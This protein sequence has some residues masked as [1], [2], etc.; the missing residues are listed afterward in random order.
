MVQALDVCGVFK[1]YGRLSVL[2]GVDLALE[3]GTFTSVLGPSGS[4]K[5]TLLRVIAGFERIDVGSVSLNGE[6]VDDGA[7]FVTPDRRR[8]GYVP[9]E[10]SLFPHLT[11]EQNVGFGLDRAHRR[12]G[13]VAH[14]LE[15]VDL[16]ALGGRYPHELSGGQQ[17]RVA[18]ARALAIAPSLVLMDEPFSSLDAALRA[19]VR[20]DVRRA[21]KAAGATVLLVTHDQDEALSLADRV[22]VIRDGRIE[23]F[24]SPE[25]LYAHPGSP[26][27]ARSVGEANLLSGTAKGEWVDTPLGLL[28][29]YGRTFA[30][31]TDLTVLVRPE[32]LVATVDASAEGPHASV[33]E[34]E[35][36]GHDVVLRLSPSWHPSVILTARQSEVWT[37]ATVGATVALNVHGPVV[38]WAAS[39]T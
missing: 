20:T 34:R 13:T 3:P 18:I 31:G 8:I 12:D 5:T 27:L 17:Q 6:L 25:R 24:A 4:G 14:Y 35:F 37:S 21:L 10:G 26:T 33:V 39:D 7:R 28:R 22:A 23:Q 38:A 32:Q 16:G 36:Y 15:M 19:E 1:G 11:V 29:L 2:R 30:D 9:Q